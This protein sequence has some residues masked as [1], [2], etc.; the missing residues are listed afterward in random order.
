[1]SKKNMTSLNQ[2]SRK[3]CK[4]PRRKTYIELCTEGRVGNKRKKEIETRLLKKKEAW[5]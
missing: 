2:V 3:S 4:K 1:M 5:T